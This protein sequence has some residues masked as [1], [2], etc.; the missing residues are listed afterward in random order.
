MKK[1]TTTFGLVALLL[2][3]T[4][5]TTPQ[6]IGGVKVPDTN[7]G[8]GGVKVPDTNYSIGGVKVPDTNFS[9]GGV[10]VPDTN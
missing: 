5:F 9:I 8:I 7:F 10:K 2:I 6:K 1:L 3:V 4:S